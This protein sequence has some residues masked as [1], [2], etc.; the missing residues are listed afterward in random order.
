MPTMLASTSQIPAS[1]RAQSRWILFSIRCLKRGVECLRMA[2]NP[3]SRLRQLDKIFQN[4]QVPLFDGMFTRSLSPFARQYTNLTDG[5][6]TAVPERLENDV[7]RR[8][9]SRKE[10]CLAGSFR[11]H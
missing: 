1:L 2:A 9:D 4:C 5:R 6:D 11:F 3:V 8:E 7:C 10:G